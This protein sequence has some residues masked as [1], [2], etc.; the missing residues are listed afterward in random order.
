MKTITTWW[1][2]YCRQQKEKEIKS[3]KNTI[4]RFLTSNEFTTQE[5][6]EM[7]IDVEKRYYRILEHKLKTN[8]ENVK[9]IKEFFVKLNN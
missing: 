1:D 9:I 8:N 5:S 4:V 3:V 6:I 2:N 7:F